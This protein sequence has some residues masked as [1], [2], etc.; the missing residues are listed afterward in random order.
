MSVESQLKEEFDSGLEALKKLNPKS[1]EYK[2]ILD[3]VLK[4]GDRLIEIDKFRS[5]IKLREVI[6][7]NEYTTKMET[8]DHEK[9]DSKMKNGLMLFT[10]VGGWT[11]AGLAFIAS[12]NF[13]R[14]ATLT[15]EGGKSSLRQLLKFR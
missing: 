14:F 12:T 1:E 11:V 9:H 5:D 13:E 10:T 2:I 8:I 4:I 7:A 3:G 15:T 6:Q